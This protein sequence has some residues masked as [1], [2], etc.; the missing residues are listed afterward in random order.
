[1]PGLHFERD[2]Q[3]PPPKDDD[4]AL[5]I[6][7]KFEFILMGAKGGL[8]SGGL[9]QIRAHTTRELHKSRRKKNQVSD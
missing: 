4:D 5:Q 3:E 7:N 1:M 9:S 6:S 2:T 8:D